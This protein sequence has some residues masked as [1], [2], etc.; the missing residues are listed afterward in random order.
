MCD[1]TSV[2]RQFGTTV[3]SVTAYDTGMLGRLGL[4]D[5]L[6]Y[7]FIVTTDV[8]KFKY[9]LSIILLA[10]IWTNDHILNV[11]QGEK[12]SHWI[13]WQEY[14][15]LYHLLDAVQIDDVGWSMPGCKLMRSASHVHPGGE[16]GMGDSSS[17]PT[18]ILQIAP[19]SSPLTARP[20]WALPYGSFGLV[21]FRSGGWERRF[22]I[23]WSDEQWL[24]SSILRWGGER[25]DDDV[26]SV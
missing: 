7:H 1:A 6:L 17:L 13:G 2:L 15:V 4:W 10:Q 5:Y 3:L 18:P 23:C 14:T 20:S 16:G 24:I 9:C 12:Y 25:D 8:I 19:S 21:G 26:G 22:G 11:K